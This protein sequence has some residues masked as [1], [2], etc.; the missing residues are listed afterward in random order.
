MNSK[1]ETLENLLATAR[2]NPASLEPFFEALWQSGGMLPTTERRSVVERAFEFIK[3]LSPPQQKDLALAHLALGYVAFHEGNYEKSLPDVV[4]ARQIFSDLGDENGVQA[5]CVMIGIDYRTLGEFEL[6]LKYLLDGYQV[7]SKTKEYRMYLLFCVYHLAEMYSE[8]G[9]Y[10]Q[11]LRFYNEL[12]KATEEAGRMNMLARELVGIGVIYLHQKKYALSLECLQQSI[13]MAEEINDIPIKARALTELGIYYEV[14]GDF[15]NAID[16][17][18]EALNI[19]RELKIPNGVITNLVHLAEL[20]IKQNHP[21]EA[22][23]LLN[24]AMKIGE[25]IKVKAKVYK[26]H[27]MLAGIYQSKGE[28][29]KSLFHYKAFYTIREE[30]QRE[31]N[32]KKIKNQ[33]LIFEAEQTKKENVIIRTQKQEIENKNRQLQETIDEL[34]ITK[35]SRKAKVFTLFIGIALIIA[36][37]PIFHFVLKQVGEENQLLNITAKVIIILSLKPIDAAVERYL[38]KRLILK[39]R[40]LFLEKNQV[41][42]A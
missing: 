24:E 3:T 13:K 2:Q 9:E 17:Q 38:L 12:E 15:R 33:H 31:D 27:E 18:K 22:I 35:I 1:I 40:K 5:A 23:G 42:S 8:S 30:V 11:A 28:L 32:Q 41:A 19:R 25:E 26:M 37:E 20:S 39:K 29:I 36:E 21:D 7:L 34:T 4:L 14:M 6:A 10:D 16:Y